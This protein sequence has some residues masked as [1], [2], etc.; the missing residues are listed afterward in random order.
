MSEADLVIRPATHADD[1]PVLALI[2]SL[3][4]GDYLLDAWPQ[5]VDRPHAITLVAERRT[6]G[7]A[8]VGCVYGEP[9]S[10]G[11][12]W[13]QGARVERDLQRLG[14]ASRLLEGAQRALHECG[15]RAVFGTVS[16]FNQPSL[17]LVAS[18]GWRV[19]A[20]VSRRRAPGRAPTED[21]ASASSPSG[22]ADRAIELLHAGQV[23]ASRRELSYFRRRYFTATPEHV[24]R[25]MALDAVRVSP[26]QCAV[27]LLDPS[28]P[29]AAESVWVVALAGGT[30]GM[31]W[32]LDRLQAEA[33]KSGRDLLV[34]CPETPELD[35]TLV[36][37]GFAPV[38]RDERFVVVRKDLAESD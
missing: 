38:R 13:M 32:L 14:I 7:G 15:S 1:A 16:A 9:T 12:A 10:A 24:A 17:V 18:L 3:D 28:A 34:D 27:A 2:R 23:L 33:G 6:A 30:E 20:R 25:Q 5:W 36:E 22:T 26:G 37:D 21:S 35:A 29:E 8:I 19:V 4:P 31:R 11:D